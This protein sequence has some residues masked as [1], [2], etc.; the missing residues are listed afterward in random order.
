[1]P[2]P[3]E[4]DVATPLVQLTDATLRKNQ[5]QLFRQPSMLVNTAKLTGMTA[6]ETPTID[7]NKLDLGYFVASYQID[8]AKKAGSL[9][10]SPND[11]KARGIE[12]IALQYDNENWTAEVDL[13]LPD[14][15]PPER[16]YHGTPEKF[17]AAILAEGLKKMKRHDVHLSLDVATTMR[18]LVDDIASGRFADEWDGER[19]NGYARLQELKDQHAGALIRDYEDELRRT[20][21]PGVASDG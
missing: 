17:V 18:E 14:S 4:G 5:L 12:V 9:A 2:T 20:L 7:K 11:P 16:L 19:D 3:L 8:D 10:L 6:D 21:G 13:Q 1:M 15:V